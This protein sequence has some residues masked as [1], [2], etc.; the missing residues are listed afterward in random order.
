MGTGNYT[1]T[2]TNMKLVRWPL[3]GGLLHLVQQGGAGQGCSLQP[4]HGPSSIVIAQS[5]T[6]SVPTIVLL[7]NGRCSAVLTVKGLR[8]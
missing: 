2:S 5:P 6:A 7:Y 3:K 4:A 8:Y 1:A